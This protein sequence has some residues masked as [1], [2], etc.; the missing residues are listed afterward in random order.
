MSS[1]LVATGI[2]ATVALLAVTLL[3]VPDDKC[4]ENI[5]TVAACATMMTITGVF[6]YWKGF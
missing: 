5:D 4:R 1:H 2:G 6:L 3:G